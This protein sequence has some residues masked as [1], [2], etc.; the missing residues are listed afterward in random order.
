MERLV[1]RGSRSLVKIFG[2]FLSGVL[3]LLPLSPIS[4][5]ADSASPEA[6]IPGE[7]GVQRVTIIMESYSFSPSDIIVHADKPVSIRLENHSFLIPHNFVIDNPVMGF[8]HEM[9]ISAGD[10][11]NFQLLLSTPGTY[12]FYCDKQ[13]LFF[14]SHRKEGMEGTLE[15]R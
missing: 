1:S 8:H 14:P 7:D 9:D 4:G 3:F 10:A 13:L 15:V 2:F 5:F 6:L 11:V 12:T